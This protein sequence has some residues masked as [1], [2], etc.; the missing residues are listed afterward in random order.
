MEKGREKT[1]W[2]K[3]LERSKLEAQQQQYSTTVV[4]VVVGGVRR[5]KMSFV[6][7][8]DSVSNGRREKSISEDKLGEGRTIGKT[9]ILL[10]LLLLLP[11]EE[12]D[13]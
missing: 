10:L 1:L 2:Q 5:E 11:E 4:V 13:D 9:C 12:D 3:N 7:L 6:V 8:P